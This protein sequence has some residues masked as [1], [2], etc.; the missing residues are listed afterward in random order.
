MGAMSSGSY[1]LRQSLGR[2]IDDGGSSC[3]HGDRPL[4]CFFSVKNSWWIFI[5][6]CCLV[7]VGGTLC[8]KKTSQ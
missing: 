6:M 4:A 8:F 1:G 5:D 7:D 3:C 2:A